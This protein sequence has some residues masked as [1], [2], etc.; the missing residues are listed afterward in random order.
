VCRNGEI[1]LSNTIELDAA[2]HIKG[3]FKL[4]DY[5]P[6]ISV[7][8]QTANNFYVSRPSLISERLIKGLYFGLLT[9]EA[10]AIQVSPLTGPLYYLL[11][12]EQEFEMVDD[13]KDKL[14]L[15]LLYTYKIEAIKEI[16]IVPKAQIKSK[17]S[18]HA[19]VQIKMN[20]PPAAPVIL[21]KIWWDWERNSELSELTTVF[22]VKITL[23]N[24][25]LANA[26]KIEFNAE[27][28]KNPKI[29]R[30]LPSETIVIDHDSTGKLILKFKVDSHI[31]SNIGVL[32]K[33]Q[34]KLQNSTYLTLTAG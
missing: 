9:N 23:S 33:N 19:P 22:A 15:D 2:D 14:T 20:T 30:K 31:T 28:G 32:V 7:E 25:N 8:M 13:L 11:S 27:I 17:K 21:S 3:I 6:N 18:K 29:Y 10:V 34:W 24:Y 4:T 1:R 12:D 16:P 26:D 5:I